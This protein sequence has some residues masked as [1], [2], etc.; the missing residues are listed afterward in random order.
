M[1]PS[2]T[3]DLYAVHP[4]FCGTSIM[5]VC[6]NYPASDAMFWT[7]LKV[8]CNCIQSQIYV[9][10]VV[11]SRIPGQWPLLSCNLFYLRKSAAYVC[12]W[13]MVE[14]RDMAFC[15]WTWHFSF[16][17]LWFCGYGT[18]LNSSKSVLQQNMSNSQRKLCFIHQTWFTP[19]SFSK[20][21]LKHKHYF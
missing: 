16:V 4:E 15:G 8:Q 11:S 19:N 3:V 1:R 18:V 10:M 2:G 20:P 7:V 5:V 9:I 6:Y 14:T 12:V 13:I 17:D 21:R